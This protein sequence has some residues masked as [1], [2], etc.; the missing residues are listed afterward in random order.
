MMMS[1]LKLMVKDWNHIW[2]TNHVKQIPKSIWVTHQILI[3][4]FHFNFL[5]IWFTVTLSFELF[6]FF[7]F[8]FPYVLNGVHC[9]VFNCVL[10]DNC[11]LTHQIFILVMSTSMR[12]FLFNHLKTLLHVKFHLRKLFRFCKSHLIWDLQP[13]KLVSHVK[14]LE[15]QLK[16]IEDCIYDLQLELE[17]NSIKWRMWVIFI[18]CFYFFLLYFD[19]I[20]QIWFVS[21]IFF[22]SLS[23]INGG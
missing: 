5:W 6:D 19:L 14:D 15:R 8:P 10:F 12:N 13:P 7:L 9:I 21:F 22:Y 17:V 2:N 11:A 4:P 16:E 20:L 1:H 18:L 3:K 23:Y